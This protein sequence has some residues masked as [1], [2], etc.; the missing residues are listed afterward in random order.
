MRGRP[1]GRDRRRKAE[2]APKGRPA[3]GRERTSM[4]IETA[5]A[6]AMILLAVGLAIGY[7]GDQR[8]VIRSARNG[9]RASGRHGALPWA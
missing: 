5:C 6:A 4:T 8:E 9:P 3:T 2:V 7:G 1:L